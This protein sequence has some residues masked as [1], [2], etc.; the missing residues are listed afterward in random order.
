M[1]TCA[2]G[3]GPKVT[4]DQGLLFFFLI[5]FFPHGYAIVLMPFIENSLISPLSIISSSHIS[6]SG[7]FFYTIELYVP[8]LHH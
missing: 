2:N 7:P 3:P 5:Y 8:S 4:P 6:V 1:T